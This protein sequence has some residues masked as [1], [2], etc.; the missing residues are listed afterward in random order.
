MFEEVVYPIYIKA[1]II[2]LC[3]LTNAIIHHSQVYTVIIT[4]YMDMTQK[5]SIISSSSVPGQW[6]A[7]LLGQSYSHK[8]PT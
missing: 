8:H 6:R 5:Q 3:S 2:S 4:L 1:S 7:L